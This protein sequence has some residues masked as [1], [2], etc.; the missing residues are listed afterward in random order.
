MP[1]VRESRVVRVAKDRIALTEHILGIRLVSLPLG[2]LLPYRLPIAASQMEPRVIGI[3]IAM[4]IVFCKTHIVERMTYLVCDR[5]PHRLTC[6]GIEPKGRYL[7]IVSTAIACPVLR[8]VHEHHHLIFR[9]VAHLRID[10]PQLVYL[11]IIKGLALLQQIIN[12]HIVEIALGQLVGI[13][14]IVLVPEYYDILRL[15]RPGLG[16]SI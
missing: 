15:T 1:L 8:M 16:P 13:L 11:Q 14:R 10:K 12:V 2:G 9:Q 5:V 4:T 6:A 3:R 7:K